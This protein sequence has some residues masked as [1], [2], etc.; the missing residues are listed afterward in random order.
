MMKELWG[1][2]GPWNVNVAHDVSFGILYITTITDT[3]IFNVI[4]EVYN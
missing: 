2:F 1:R 3:V 4:T